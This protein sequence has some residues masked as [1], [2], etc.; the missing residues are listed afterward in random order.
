[1]RLTKAI[2][3]Y[4]IPILIVT[5][6]L[7]IPAAIMMINTRVNFD[8]LTYLPEDMETNIGQKQL[9]EDFN[10]GGFAFLIFENMSKGDIRETKKAIEAVE[11]VDTVIWPE[12]LTDGK[13]PADLLPDEIYHEVNNGKATL[14]AVFFDSPTSA[15]ETLQAAE[16]IRS[17]G[18]EHCFN[19][20]MT[21]LVLDLKNLCEKEEIIYVALAVIL[22]LAVMLLFLDSWLIPF[23]FLIS[24]GAMIL[25]NMGTNF[26][27]GEISFITKALAA[28]LQ[29]A[30]TMDYSIF[31]WHSYCE[32]CLMVPDHHEAMAAAIKE[33]FAA[34]IGSSVT[35]IAGFIALCFM[36][37]TLGLDLGL[38]MA[39]GVLFGVIGCVTVLPA[40]I[41]VFDKPL[42]KTR[43][44]AL[45]PKMDG[46]AKTVTKIFPAVLIIF[47]VL[48]VPSYYGYNK[49]QKEVYY[50]I[51][52]S[53]PQD[54]DY[55]IAS[56][57]LK[58]EFNIAST[59]MV[60]VSADI[61]ASTIHQIRDE[62]EKVDG[63]KYVIGLE[64]LLGKKVPREILPD[65]VL[66]L[67]RSE[68]WELMLI[69][70]EY[71]VATDEIRQQ[72]ADLKRILKKYD[73]GGMLIGEPCCTEDM[74][75]V[76]DHDF[77]VVNI[78]SIIAVFLIILLVER[79]LTLP[80]ILILIIEAGIFFNLG[81]PHYLGQQMSF[82]DPICISTIQ[83]GAT[84][85]YAIL[86]TTRYKAK[87]MG[88]LDKRSAIEIAVKTSVPSIIVSALVLFAATFGV[89]MYSDVE[90]ISSIC[91]LLARGAMISG[92]LVSF[93]L[94]AMFMAADK[95]ICKATL[96]MRKIDY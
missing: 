81:L 31:L 4:R 58:D 22:C 72:I 70:S 76:T 60:L 9:L 88:G 47:A 65:S 64:S 39:K 3:K 67:A 24:I 44:K 83:L 75:A 54:M 91:M 1:M 7:L 35:T 74:I 40:L 77:K 49:A 32:Q 51:S 5:L 27:F 45:M 17:I 14:M 59:H 62:M 94:P 6:I 66:E 29:L 15:D 13:V 30:V 38:V 43:H 95:V 86:M 10:K 79:S 12:D 63:V 69:N 46:V 56:A 20:G 55:M 26:F 2:V 18:G 96:G 89:A 57:K 33:T 87:R 25:I 36:S 84:V 19:A 21:A 23:L 61:P 48:A 16:R 68:R 80:V 37:F 52:Q 90:L 34:V 28:V 82:F 71:K 42:Q 85:D 93:V 78:I 8:M 41:L 50:D 11:H 73:S 92:V 53:L